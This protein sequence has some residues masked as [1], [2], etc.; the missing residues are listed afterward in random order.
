MKT[1]DEEAISF[2]TDALRGLFRWPIAIA[3]VGVFVLASAGIGAYDAVNKAALPELVGAEAEEDEALREA[4]NWRDGSSA[5][6]YERD[7][8]L[9]STA[10]KAIAPYYAFGL[11][12]YFSEAKG[13]AHVGRDGWIFVR[14]RV[15]TRPVSE[16]ENIGMGGSV[17]SLV[18][19]RLAG[20]G[21]D[22]C[23]ILIPRKCVIEDE[24]MPRAV[25]SNP[26][27]YD[28]LLRELGRRGV[29]VA[30]LK[31]ALEAHGD[32]RYFYK[33]DTH[34]NETAML[35]AA[36]EACRAAGILLSEENLTTRVVSREGVSRPRDLFRY[37]GI[38]DLGDVPIGIEERAPE[39]YFV[40][41]IAGG[42]KHV[43]KQKKLPPKMERLAL[44]GTSFS[45]GKM[46]HVFLQ[47]FSGT[48]VYDGSI[49][50]G[51]PMRPLGRLWSEFEKKGYPELLFW[52]LPAHYVFFEAPFDDYNLVL[53]TMP[54]AHS[55]PLDVP[56]SGW[57]KGEM[58]VVS[59]FQEFASVGRSLRHS[60]D[61]C[62]S[63][64]IRGKLNKV[65]ARIAVETAGLKMQY[66][67][68]KE[69]D[70]LVVPLLGIDDVEGAKISIRSRRGLVML[71]LESVDVV[72]DL[73]LEADSIAIPEPTEAAG[74][75]EA[76]IE[77]A[78]ERR[79][80]PGAGLLLKAGV[81]EAPKGLRV[82]L[83]DGEGQNVANLEVGDLES[84]QHCLVSVPVNREVSVA[85]IILRGSNASALRA[86]EELK[87]LELTKK[88]GAR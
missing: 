30:D 64:R 3:V 76:L 66:E 41:E 19:R 85:K 38:D 49:R 7:L 40:K 22:L 59:R 16:R 55:A 57:E 58:R 37:L 78:E 23:L 50:G 63:L 29:T 12:R 31:S 51:G 15:E 6:L 10:Y 65:G 25:D 80:A 77:F 54:P 11:Y 67:W 4:A 75:A 2:E 21:V 69:V 47:H 60:G 62:V 73:S 27:F 24:F 70:E 61:G 46:H 28:L 88:P 20:V 74:F 87:L 8:K 33:L 42:K 79:I 9:Q 83:L 68:D 1:S 43:K 86:I 56:V 52:E 18:R 34:W 5:R 53:P 72:T 35:V 81:S 45:W 17:I 84:T 48:R 14:N 71:D 26:H 13:T 44:V 82:Q 39:R 36:K 32:R